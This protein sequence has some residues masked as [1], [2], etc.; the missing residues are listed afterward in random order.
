MTW[1]LLKAGAEAG[2]AL[3]LIG[4]V[5]AGANWEPILR[6]ARREKPQG[7]LEQLDKCNLWEEAVW[8]KDM[9]KGP[10]G[11]AAGKEKRQLLI[12]WRKRKVLSTL[13]IHSM[14]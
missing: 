10:Q 14:S 7:L 2:S 5:V 11:P 9:V 1:L 12:F 4:Q 8:L 13:H 3:G 6:A